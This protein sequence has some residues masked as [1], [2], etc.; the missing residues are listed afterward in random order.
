MTDVNATGNL[1]LLFI[2]DISG[3]TKFVNATEISHSQHIISELLELIIDSNE[4]DL[5][6][7]EIEGDAVMFYE[8]QNI[9]PLEKLLKQVERMFLAFHRQL[10]L[11]EGY[12]VC[13]C[14]ACGGATELTLKVVVHAGFVTLINVKNHKKPYGPDVI[15]AHRLLKNDVQNNEYFLVTDRT[16]NIMKENDLEAFG[17]WAKVNEG[18]TDYGDIGKISYRY[19]ELSP[20]LAKLAAPVP[21]GPGKKAPPPVVKEAF[22]QR[23]MDQLYEIVSDLEIRAKWVKGVDRIDHD[24]GKKNH[25][26]AKHVCVIDSRELK[27]ETVV[28]DNDKNRR[29]YGER[30]VNAPLLKEMIIYYIFESSG[31]GTNL[32]IEYHFFPLPLFGWLL[33]PLLRKGIAK[34]IGKTIAALKEYSETNQ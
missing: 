2:P 11:Y 31:T 5:T 18:S 27:F 21:P 6:L 16:F 3:F 34:N 1:S 26:G 4:L 10:K 8:Y 22:I 9:P 14:G 33:K 28:T 30:L 19:I 13:N 20:L 29:I 25:I 32:R 12:R 17:Q 23:P 7:A 15:L 24:K